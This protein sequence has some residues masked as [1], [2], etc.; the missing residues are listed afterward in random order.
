[1]ATETNGHVS[2][3]LP[4]YANGTLGPA[5]R[6]AIDAHLAACARCRAELGWL[7]ELGTQVRASQAPPAGDLGLER[8]LDRIAGDSNIVPLRR[9]PRPRWMV[10]AVA[11]AASLLVAQAITIGVLLQDRAAVLQTLGG[12]TADGGALLQVTFAPQATEAQIRALLAAAGARIV[13]GPGAL[14]VY[15]LSVAPGEVDEAQRKLEQ[16]QDIVASVT[17][18]P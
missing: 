13:D 2:E 17:R 11:L 12:S 3:L 18:L 14:G 4:W 10:P 5:Q 15:T 7:R 6:D 1:M 9:A 16:T 8:F